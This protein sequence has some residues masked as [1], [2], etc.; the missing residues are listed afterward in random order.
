MLKPDFRYELQKHMNIRSNT[1]SWSQPQ[2]GVPQGTL[3]GPTSFVLYINDMKTIC[4]DEQHVDDT[5]IWE[6][7]NRSGT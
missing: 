5:T 2:A 1:S 6:Y 3:P 4:N 7:S